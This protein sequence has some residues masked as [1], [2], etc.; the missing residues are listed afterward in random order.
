MWV[1]P[2][3]QPFAMTAIE[4][5]WAA[6]M[7]FA[8]AIMQRWHHRWGAQLV[9]HFGTMLNVRVEQTPETVDDTWQLAREVAHLSDFL[10]AETSVR[11]AAHGLAHTRRWT[12]H[13]RP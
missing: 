8:L 3:T 13:S 9:G 10:T 1:I 11:N 7:P 6:D 4:H 12:V 5:H 2:R